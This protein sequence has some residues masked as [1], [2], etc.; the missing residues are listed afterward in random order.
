M[1]NALTS[2]IIAVALS[3]TT[4]AGGK[5]VEPAI[6]PVVPVQSDT[7]WYIGIGMAWAQFVSNN[8]NCDYEDVTYGGMIRAGYEYSDYIDIEARY[9]YTFLEEGPF[10]GAPL[11][12]VGLYLKPTLPI[13]EE[14]EVY[15]LLGYG[16]TKN[17]GNGARLNRFDDDFG[18]SAGMGA[19]YKFSKKDLED[20]TEWSIFI[21]YQRLLIKSDIPDMDVISLGLRMD[22]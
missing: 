15:A 2:L 11:Q 12:H 18:F 8:D 10:G 13:S 16:Y 19:E 17:K 9:I 22:F 3:I 1:K 21:D 4:Y 14:I 6:I 5:G 20:D 7:P